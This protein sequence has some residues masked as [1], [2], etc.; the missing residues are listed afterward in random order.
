MKN[1][2]WRIIQFIFCLIAFVPGGVWGETCLDFF[3]LDSSL[4]QEIGTRP[5]T[6]GLIGYLDLLLEKGVIG[7]LNLLRLVESLKK[8]G[9]VNPIDETEAELD[10]ELYEHFK[11]LEEYR[12]ASDLEVQKLLSWANRRSK[13]DERVRDERSHLKEKLKEIFIRILNSVYFQ[14][15]L[16]SSLTMMRGL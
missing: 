16:L 5:S 2:Q 9:I 4:K 13:I 12:S 7:E 6:E 14:L 3:S 15:G 10:S 8:G 11:G 1:T